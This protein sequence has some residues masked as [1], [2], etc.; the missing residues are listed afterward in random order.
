[1]SVLLIVIIV[2]ALAAAYL[3]TGM[4]LAGRPYVTRQVQQHCERHPTLAEDYAEEWRREAAFEALF[5]TAVWPLYLAFRSLV[6]RVAEAA[7]LSDH[8]LRRQLA[9]RDRRIAE[10]ERELGVGTRRR[11]NSEHA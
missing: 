5:V 3:R 9:D 2:L 6:S 8:E 4:R 7:P 10:L 11:S 1:M